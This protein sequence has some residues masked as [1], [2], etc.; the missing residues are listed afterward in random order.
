MLL[1]TASFGVSCTTGSATIPSGN[2][3]NTIM[4]NATIRF[5]RNAYNS[6]LPQRF[7]IIIFY[8]PDDESE[9]YAKRIIGLPGEIVNIREGKI[10]INEDNSPLD[11]SFCY[12]DSRSSN[13]FGTYHVPENSYFVLGDNRNHSLDSRHWRN[14]F[15]PFEN[16]I[17]K[18]TSWNNP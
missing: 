1:I 5:D 18:V 15:V 13:E 14:S 7:D 4:P 2:M 12:P 16:I 10:Y 8:S 3:M 11:D 17:G 6:Q 9:T